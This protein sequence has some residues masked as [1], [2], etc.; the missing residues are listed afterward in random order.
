[1][2]NASHRGGELVFK[3]L[4]GKKQ[5]FHSPSSVRIK[6]DFLTFCIKTGVLRYV[7]DDGNFNEDVYI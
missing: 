3:L 2:Q 1:M 6:I 4:R 7:L 5:F